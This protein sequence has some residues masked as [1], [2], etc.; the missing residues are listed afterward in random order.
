MGLIMNFLD[1]ENRVKSWPS[2]KS[3]KIEVLK[4]IAS[5]FEED[6]VYTEKEVNNIIDQWHTFQDYFML[7]RGMIDY[8]L[9]G[10]TR[11]G[12]EYW[13]LK[14]S[15]SPSEMIIMYENQINELMKKYGV[16]EMRVFGSIARGED[17]EKSDADFIVDMPTGGLL[18]YGELKYA[19]ENLLDR[20]IDMLTFSSLD[21]DVLEHFK[22]KS[23]DIFE[24]KK[25]HRLQEDEH[26]D[27]VQM[28][29]KSM[30]W[31]IERILD[32]THVTEQE[33]MENTVLKDAV[34]RNVQLLGQVASQIPNDFNGMIL[35]H[36]IPLRDA[37]FMNVDYTM[38]WK[39]VVDEL[40]PLKQSIQNY[41]KK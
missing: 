14:M 17:T 20:P 23:M 5:K 21:K 6:K 4:Y 15:R 37:L 28:N 11:T 7:R 8:K 3:K 35:Q 27:K 38:L 24:L 25:N 2:K 31:V 9:L 12:S 22:R 1:D 26:M 10:R 41:L 39:T 19:L 32:M 13:K 18:T 36:C 33:F 16:R 40:K 30:L 34:T 29:L